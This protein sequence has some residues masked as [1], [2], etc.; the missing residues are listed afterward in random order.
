VGEETASNDRVDHFRRAADRL[1]GVADLQPPFDVIAVRPSLRC[2]AM[3][4][5]DCDA[6]APVSHSIEA[7]RART[8]PATRYRDDRD[9]VSF[10]RT[11]LWTPGRP[12]ILARPRFDLAA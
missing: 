7:P 1:G 12:M 5:S 11:T 8:L 4:A 10:T 2:A 9:R 3:V 6:L